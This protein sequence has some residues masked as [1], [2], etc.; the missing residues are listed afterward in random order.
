M[1]VLVVD[2]NMDTAESMALLVRGLGHEVDFAISGRLA[3]EVAR[4][5]RPNIVF[6]DLGLPDIDGCELAGQ[7]R[8]EAGAR[9]IAVTGSGRLDDR[10]RALQSGCD[11]YV[12]KPLDVKFLTSL[13]GN[14]LV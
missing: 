8:G 3:L 12:V 11:D 6:L 4:A 1:R 14:R 10:E 9:I 7:L 5:F 2:D 13:L